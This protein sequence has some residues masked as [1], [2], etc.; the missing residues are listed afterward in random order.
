M[1][2]NARTFARRKSSGVRS[3]G[4]NFYDTGC[5]RRLPKSHAK[6]GCTRSRSGMVT[7]WVTA[8]MALGCQRRI[9]THAR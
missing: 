5:Q 7:R 2:R 6:L 8:R 1:I 4:R 9:S 3:A